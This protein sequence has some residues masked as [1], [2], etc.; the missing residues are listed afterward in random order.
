MALMALVTL[1]GCNKD[2][3]NNATPGG[4]DG[5]GE[6]VT[7]IEAT[8][9]YNL[10]P[11]E[12]DMS[13]IATVKMI[14][15]KNGHDYVI[16]QTDFKDNGFVLQLPS[17][18]DESFLRSVMD[19]FVELNVSDA[20][21]MVCRYFDDDDFAPEAFDEN[22]NNIGCFWS[23]SNNC[24]MGLIYADRKVEI[25]GTRVGSGNYS[26]CYDLDLKKGW[27]IVYYHWRNFD[28]NDYNGISGIEEAV[29]IEGIYTSTKPE[30]E[31][32]NWMFYYYSS[33]K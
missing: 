2:E 15:R 24:N 28:V 29:N 11:E 23:E 33:E 26:Y 9:I 21:A 7:K 32:F 30:D 3:N 8:N 4:N 18:L 22:G 13:D 17:N 6:I 16:E 14:Y 19:A 10:T 12:G 20:N 27:N 1:T 31:Y 5:G 25:N